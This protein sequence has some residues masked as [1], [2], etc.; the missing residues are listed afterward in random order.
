MLKGFTPCARAFQCIHLLTKVPTPYPFFG[1]TNFETFFLTIQ[2][3]TDRLQE[4]NLQ[5]L[6][7]R[8]QNIFH[9][10]YISEYPLPPHV[11]FFIL[12]NTIFLYGC[13][14]RW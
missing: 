7:P 1:Q 14:L 13:Q 4:V 11:N 8:D 12:F 3:Q 5:D 2:R 9:L 10:K 6:F